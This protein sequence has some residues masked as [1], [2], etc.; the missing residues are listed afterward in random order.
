MS[1]GVKVCLLY[2]WPVVSPVIQCSVL[3]IIHL[4][5]MCETCV[6]HVCYTCI[7]VLPLMPPTYFCLNGGFFG[8]LL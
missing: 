4:Y 5:Y 7:T 8:P 3:G 6:L 1:Q 2:T